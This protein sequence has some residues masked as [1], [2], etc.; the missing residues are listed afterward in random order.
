MWMFSFF[1][2]KVLLALKAW[3]PW[4][5]RFERFAYLLQKIKTLC[6]RP[7]INT[8]VS[9]PLSCSVQC[10]HSANGVI[11]LDSGKLSC[12]QTALT[13]AEVY[14]WTHPHWCAYTPTWKKTLFTHICL[15]FPRH[16]TFTLEID[17]A[18]TKEL[19]PAT[20]GNIWS[21]RTAWKNR[22]VLKI[23]IWRIFI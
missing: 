6:Y 16:F 17:M 23:E 3:V 21:R 10:H 8:K 5:L 11:C 2:R 22:K 13:V 4:I 9:Y 12:N 15:T 18:F 19:L 20:R 1:E 14:T 7:N